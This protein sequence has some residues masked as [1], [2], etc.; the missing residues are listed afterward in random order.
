MS[1]VGLEEMNKSEVLQYVLDVHE[2]QLRKKS[3]LEV[4]IKRTRELDDTLENPLEVGEEVRYKNEDGICTISKAGKAL[5]ITDA[6]GE[7]F[8][9]ERTDLARVVPKPAQPAS[10]ETTGTEESET[11]PVPQKDS[12]DVVPEAKADEA[13]VPAETTAPEP[14][15]H[16]PKVVN[17]DSYRPKPGGIVIGAL[18]EDGSANTRKTGVTHVLDDK[19][20][21]V[22]AD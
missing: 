20:E 8:D 22:E 21:T 15:V 9:V 13:S 17:R 5:E 1:A 11:K 18:P 4:L 12:E 14:R 3:Q 10:D 19:V 16:Y 2:V 6:G 7:V